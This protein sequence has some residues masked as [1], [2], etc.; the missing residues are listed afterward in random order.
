MSLPL[1]CFDVKEVG[2]V[3]EVRFTG[4]MAFD[5]LKSQDLAPQI[6]ELTGQGCRE[7]RLDL[8]KVYYLGSEGLAQFVG[9]H[10]RLRASGGQL[11]LR[12]VPPPVYELFEITRLHTFLDV[13]RA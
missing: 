5:D 12:N 8:G 11:V 4:A 10:K 6:L 9:L 2:D 3:T 1:D 7:L 13:R